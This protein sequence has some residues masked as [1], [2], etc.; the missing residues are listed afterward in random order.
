LASS[1]FLR[2][3]AVPAGAPRPLPSPG[4]TW[5]ALQAAAEA[6]TRLTKRVVACLDVR[7]NDDGD[8]VVTKG[9]QYDVREQVRPPTPLSLYACAR[10]C[11]CVFVYGQQN[12]RREQ[13][14]APQ[15]PTARWGGGYQKGTGAVRNLGKPAELARAYYEGGADE[16]VFLNITSFRSSPLGD[17]PML[18]LLQHTSESVFVP[19]TVGGGIRELTDPDGT[20]HS[21]LEVAAA[22]FRSG[23]DKVSIGGDAV[24]AAEAW[25]AR[26]VRAQSHREEEVQP[27]A[28]CTCAPRHRPMHGPF[29]MRPHRHKQTNK[30]T[31]QR[32][33]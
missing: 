23:A 10:A 14:S 3:Y 33:C 15:R 30:Q 9:D 7:S 27:H 29:A 2:A 21:A 20:T 22:Y 11:V 19:L 16:V 5:A 12:C 24:L 4:P 1:R 17:L 26:C 8:L 13:P 25:L 6:P 18:A 28:R 31:R 32:L